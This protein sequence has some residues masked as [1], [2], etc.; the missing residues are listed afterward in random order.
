MNTMV[1]TSESEIGSLTLAI[2][3]PSNYLTSY[4]EI[5]LILLA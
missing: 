4:V 2:N 1:N 5:F 3:T